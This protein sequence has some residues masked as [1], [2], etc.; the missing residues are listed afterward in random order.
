MRSCEPEDGQSFL[1]QDPF[2]GSLLNTT[3]CHVTCGACEPFVQ[4]GPFCLHYTTVRDL[5]EYVLKS[6]RKK[7]LASVGSCSISFS[8][9]M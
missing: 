1:L 5:G 3:L 2:V 7:T 4:T 6:I 8:S 9:I